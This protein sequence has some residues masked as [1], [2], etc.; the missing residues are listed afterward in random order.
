MITQLKS[1]MDD[2]LKPGTGVEGYEYGANLHTDGTPLIDSATGKTIVI[3]AFEFKMNPE[4][5]KDF[6][7]DRQVLFDA[8]AKQITTIL[9]GDG[10]IPLASE[11]PRVIIDKKALKYNIF[12]PCE[13]RT[14][15]MFADRP[16]SLSEHLM[17]KNGTSRHEK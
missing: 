6:P 1:G 17:K 7:Q 8:H 12:V 11:P 3:R 16:K 15:T 4:A 10:L 13:A 5:V 14:S 9:W 2:K